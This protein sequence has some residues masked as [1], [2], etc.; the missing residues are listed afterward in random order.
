MEADQNSER[1]KAENAD[2]EKTDAVRTEIIHN[3]TEL[4]THYGFWKTNI[5]DIATCCSMSPGNLYR[6]FKNKQAI[7]LAVVSKYFEMVEVALETV[8]MLP[9]GTPEERIRKWL[10][11]GV[12]QGVCQVDQHPKIVELAEFL[13]ED[14]D[15]WEMLQEHIRWKREHLAVEI[16]KGIDSG[17]LAPCDPE[18]TAA[19]LLNALKAFWM[20]M[21]LAKWK[22]KSTIL[23]E[24][25]ETLDLF[26]RGLRA[27]P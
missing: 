19:I 23:P 27:R 6:Y 9:G 4:F 21:T 24:L 12:Q 22:D 13:V 26:F 14:S 15:G 3:A 8:E 17:D 1:T 25:H 18:R 20:P 2:A 10:E 7:G 5:G 11:A 16:Q